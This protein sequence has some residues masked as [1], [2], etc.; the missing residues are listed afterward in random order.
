MAASVIAIGKMRFAPY[1]AAA[2]EYLKR[3]KH[4]V[5]IQ[6]IELKSEA[7]PKLNEMQIRERESRQMMELVAPSTYLFV[8]D[9]RGKLMN[10]VQFSEVI[11]RLMAQSQDM[12]FV[13]G[14][15]YGHHEC[16]RQRANM[17][18]G[19]SPLTFPHELARVL[20]YEQIYR[21]MTIL[22]NEPY[23]K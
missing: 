3:L 17:V 4:Y 8:L 1:R 15:A 6:E 16:L 22:K 9:E 12:A 19:L 18:F 10:S 5:N 13:I 23:H 7:T 21:A 20:V 2:D 14:G 11:G